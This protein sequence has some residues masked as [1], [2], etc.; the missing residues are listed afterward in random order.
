[1]IRKILP[2]FIKVPGDGEEILINLSLVTSIKV[3]VW[4]SEADGQRKIYVRAYNQEGGYQI[5]NIC[6]STEAAWNW[7]DENIPVHD[8]RRA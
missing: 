4:Q 6:E 2:V 8:F 7:I 3:Y 1:M 5:L